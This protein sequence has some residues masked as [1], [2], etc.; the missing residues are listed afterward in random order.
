[1]VKQ[2]G[3]VDDTL[4]RGTAVDIDDRDAHDRRKVPQTSDDALDLSATV[5]Q[6]SAIPVAV[7]G[8]QHFGLELTKPVHGASGT[9]VG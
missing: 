7:N 5:V 3:P 2:L 6:F 8:D 1:M 4:N 9:K